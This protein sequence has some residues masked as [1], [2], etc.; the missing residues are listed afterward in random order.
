MT[1][2]PMR[3]ALNLGYLSGRADPAEVLAL[4]RHAERLGFAAVWAAEAYSSD[5]PSVLAWLAGQTPRSTSGRRSCRSR[6]A[7]RR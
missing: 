7:A 3:L 5:S 2:S 4:T 1:P 6:A